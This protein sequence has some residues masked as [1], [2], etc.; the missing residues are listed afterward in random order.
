M[1][2]PA[3]FMLSLGLGAVIALAGCQLPGG[4]ARPGAVGKVI[5]INAG[6]TTEF[7][8]S[9]GQIWLADTGFADGDVVD[10]GPDLAIAKTKDPYLYRTEHYG[11]TAFSQTVPNGRYVVKLHF[12]ETYDG[13]TDK[14]Q[15]VFS[16][17]VE[18]RE[19]KDFDVWAKAGGNQTAYIETVP[20]DVKD[21]KLDI[22]FTATEQQPEINAIEIVPD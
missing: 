19:F 4:N 18:G 7:K 16:F 14:G 20:V 17:T 15:R 3:R 2:R 22:L 11:M 10:R 12:A 6:S 21:G 5:R 8:D 13:I 9:A 1:F